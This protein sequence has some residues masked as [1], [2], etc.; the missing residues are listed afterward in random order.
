MRSLGFALSFVVTLIAGCGGAFGDEE[1]A[2]LKGRAAFDF[3]CPK[4]EIKTV[5]IDDRTRG[6]SGCG[7]RGSYVYVCSRRAYTE[8]CTWVLNGHGKRRDDDD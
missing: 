6:A 2:E 5:T 7:H 8:D 4:S 3:D 1:L